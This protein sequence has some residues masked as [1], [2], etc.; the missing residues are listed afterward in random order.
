MS[1]VTTNIMSFCRFRR[2]IRSQAKRI[3][4]LQQRLKDANNF[5]KQK[6]INYLSK[7]FNP[8]QMTFMELQLR[9]IGKRNHGQRYTIE[10]KTMMLAIYK[11]G[12]RVYRCVALLF[13]LPSRRT[14]C[15]H[16]ARLKFGTGINAKLFE[17][18][19][20]TA[21]KL[22][23]S[24]KICTL[25]WDEMALT[26]HVSYCTSE[27]YIDGFV[28][29]GDVRIPDFATH[30]LTFTIRGVNKPFKQPVV[31]FYSQNLNNLQLADL[32]KLVIRSVHDA[33]ID[34]CILNNQSILPF[35]GLLLI[36][37]YYF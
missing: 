19:N 32:I 15:R 3:K 10:E 6:V 5:G 8:D 4:I 12:P 22:G 9:N 35:F 13:G 27:D 28:D 14:L 33:G 18:L 34:F 23:P 25:G 2:Q 26:H 37:R 20:T 30:S 16:S 36:C 24:D 17:L 1:F 11:R 29:L 31:Y 21:S 7:H